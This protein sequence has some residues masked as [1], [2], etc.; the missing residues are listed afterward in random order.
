MCSAAETGHLTGWAPRDGAIGRTE[1]GIAPT[2]QKICDGTRD[3]RMGL[4]EALLD[5]AKKREW[6]KRQ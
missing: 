2:P 4:A 5:H 3:G 6:R 1:G